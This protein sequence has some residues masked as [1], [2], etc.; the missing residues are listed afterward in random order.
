MIIDFLVIFIAFSLVFNK[1][2]IDQQETSLDEEVFFGLDV[3]SDSSW[4]IIISGIYALFF[5]LWNI[6]VLVI[7]LYQITYSSSW[8]KLLETIYIIIGY[9]LGTFYLS[10][11]TLLSIVQMLSKGT[12]KG[13]AFLTLLCCLILY[14]LNTGT[15]ISFNSYQQKT[16][17]KAENNF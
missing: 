17:T 9:F 16:I 3:A 10:V 15:C 1:M 6:Y 2:L 12:D 14:I 13:L 7:L 11:M 5:V 4:V 8:L